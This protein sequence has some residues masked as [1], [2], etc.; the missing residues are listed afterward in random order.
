MFLRFDILLNRTPL[1]QQAVEHAIGLMHHAIIA[2]SNREIRARE[3]W[4]AHEPLSPIS[5]Y[6][7]YFGVKVSLGKPVNA[8]FLSSDDFNRPLRKRDYRLYDL[9]TNFIETRFPPVHALLSLQVR[10]VGARLLGDGNCSHKEV[11]EKLGIHPRTLQRRLREEGTSFEEIKDDIRRD[12][13][14]RYLGEKSISLTR[15]AT[16]LGYSEPSVLTRSCYRWFST[17]P[18]NIRRDMYSLNDAYSDGE[19]VEMMAS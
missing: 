17:S 1:K 18:R 10:A 9:A 16:M 13:A 2:M 6:Q 7:R 3:I 4:F 8:I 14:L 19:D 11:A 12:I 5:T 15:L